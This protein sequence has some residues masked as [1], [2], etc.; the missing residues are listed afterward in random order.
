MSGSLGLL[1]HFRSAVIPSLVGACGSCAVHL[2]STETVDL[3]TEALLRQET[4]PGLYVREAP[5]YLSVF[6]KSAIA[7]ACASSKPAIALP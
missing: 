6:T 1:T 5:F 3:R 4:L 2:S 7:L